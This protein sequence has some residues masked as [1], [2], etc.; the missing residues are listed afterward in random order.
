MFDEDGLEVNEAWVNGVRI[1]YDLI[2]EG[3]PVVLLGGTGMPIFWWDAG[4]VRSALVSAGYQVLAFAARGVAPSEAPAPPYTV[5][6]LAADAGALCEHLGLRDCRFVG[7]SLGGFTLEVL[8][9]ARPDL[10]RAGVFI[11]SAG[12]TTE[13][14][15]ML[16]RAQR[17]LFAA[18]GTLPDSSLLVETLR[19]AVPSHVLQD[20]APQVT[21]WIEL[22]ALPTWRH[23]DGLHGQLAAVWDWFDEDQRM[24]L[25]ARIAAPCLVI[26]FEHDLYFPPR[27]GRQATDVLPYGEFLEIFQAGHAGII[28]HA[29]M[30]TKA[31]LDFFG[32][33]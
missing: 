19:T 26:A 33:F 31:M 20:D 7:V 2:G 12:P 29:D 4:N 8:A 32:R 17:D 24:A 16:T 9:R 30:C 13:F 25:L 22:L 18:V 27:G 14:T 6:D 3:E 5:D 11:G 1:A 28:T 15:R 23:R 10:V 21:E